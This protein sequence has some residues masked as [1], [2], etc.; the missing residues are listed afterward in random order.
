MTKFFT[1]N[2]T[3]RG[4]ARVIKIKKIPRKIVFIGIISAVV[5]F[6]LGFSI[7]SII[8]GNKENLFDS[9]QE[10]GAINFLENDGDTQYYWTFE[11]DNCVLYSIDKN[12][13]IVKQL[14]V[15]P[16]TA[17]EN[18]S[19]IDFGICGDWIIVSVGHYEGSGN[20]FYGD[21][22]R[23]KKDGT[24]LEH[25]WLTDDDTFI[26]VDDWIYYNYWTI[27]DSDIA[28]GSYRIRPD[29]TGKEYM[30]DIFR[31]IFFYSQE[32][33]LYAE[34]DTGETINGV[35]PIT[36]LIRSNPDGS[37]FVILFSG[38]TL[39]QF[40]S[41]DYMHYLDVNT[42]DDFVTFTVAVHGYTEGDAWWGH[43]NYI[44]DYRVNKDGSELTLLS[45]EFPMLAAS[46]KVL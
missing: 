8:N 30:G 11:A 35:N 1:Q 25:F 14:A 9:L 4:S 34:H 20:Y 41:S 15:F 10:N 24:E 23:M 40:D 12:K 46:D 16:P 5:L 21:F 2:A 17:N 7:V 45:E 39:L 29:S 19:I 42:N 27:Q 22:V 18:N 13:S 3:E 31:S 36:D 33:Y 6:F 38:E 28:N 37:E 32:G 26:I 43:Y 44:A